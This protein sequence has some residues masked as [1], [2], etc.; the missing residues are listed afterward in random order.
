[1]RE[2][3]RERPYNSQ[4]ARIQN[5]QCAAKNDAAAAQYTD[6]ARSDESAATT[7]LICNKPGTDRAEHGADVQN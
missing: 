5:Q 2:S 1:M 4:P 7:K 3:A 6:D